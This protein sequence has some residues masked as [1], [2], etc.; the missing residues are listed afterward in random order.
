VSEILLCFLN[1]VNDEQEDLRKQKELIKRREV[2]CAKITAVSRMLRVFSVLRYLFHS[3]SQQP[4]R[5]FDITFCVFF[6]F[7]V[8]LRKERETIMRIKGLSPSSKLPRGLLLEGSEAITKGRSQHTHT[9]TNS[10]LYSPE[11]FFFVLT[12][13][14][15]FFVALGDFQRAKILDL[16]NEKRPPGRVLWILRTGTFFLSNESHNSIN[17]KSLV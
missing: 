2:I 9:H 8:C 15:F 1:L 3:S 10:E 4:K 5:E 13:D 17:E 14:C 6:V 7:F 11:N 16:P 12:V